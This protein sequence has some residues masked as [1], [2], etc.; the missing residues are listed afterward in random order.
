MH[1]DTFRCANGHCIPN[2]WKCDGHDDCHDNSD[3][4][5]CGK[6]KIFSLFNFLVPHNPTLCS[7]LQMLRFA[8]SSANWT[9]TVS[10]VLIIE[11]ASSALKS[12]MVLHSAQI[13]RMKIYFAPERNSVFCTTV[14]T[15]AFYCP[16]DQNVC[17]LVGTLPLMISIAKTST[18]AKLMVRYYFLYYFL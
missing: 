7:Y 10:C 3:E 1:C 5:G 8:Q 2:E 11:R 14:P 15:N 18:N 12:V 6:R 9:R 17:V 13:N 16:Q 4:I